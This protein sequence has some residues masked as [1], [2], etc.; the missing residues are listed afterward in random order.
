MYFKMRALSPHPQ[1]NLGFGFAES[2]LGVD[3]HKISM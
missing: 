2:Q 1:I 3:P